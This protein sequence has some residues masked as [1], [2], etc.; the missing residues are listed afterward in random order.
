MIYNTRK[1]INDTKESQK[2]KK[3]CFDAHFQYSQS[4]IMVLN[5]VI[6]KL[7]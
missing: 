3:D 1:Q 6:K 2:G 5:K 7:C 4:K